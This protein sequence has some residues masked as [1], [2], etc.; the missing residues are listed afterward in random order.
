MHGLSIY[1]FE[2]KQTIGGLQINYWKDL[3]REVMIS[4]DVFGG[5]HKD[6]FKGGSR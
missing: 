4:Y 3:S 6:F 1:S 2:K 5:H